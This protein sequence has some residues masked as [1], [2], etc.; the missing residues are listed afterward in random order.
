M[1]QAKSLLPSRYKF[2]T[3]RETT[4]NLVRF[5]YASEGVG[6]HLE[7][8]PYSE[9]I[10]HI[11]FGE[12]IKLTSPNYEIRSNY[13][14]YKVDY[15]DK[16][17]YISEKWI[18]VFPPPFKI[19]TIDF[20]A[21]RLKENDFDVEIDIYNME[22][23]QEFKLLFPS[24]NM[25]EIFNIASLLY[26]MDFKYPRKS[27][28]MEEVLTKINNDKDIYEEF[29]VTRNTNEE[30]IMLDYVAD[31]GISSDSITLRLRSDGMI[32]LV[33]GSYCQEHKPL[34]GH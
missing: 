13:K 29:E 16:T 26:P 3:K 24:E 17:L 25:R 20:Y 8:Y 28:M 7:P 10:T 18:G 11:P 4:E 1:S 6:L 15:E 30:V 22:D 27:N 19:E 32:L 14:W 21:E 5:V 12:T 23:R 31:F 34:E 9:E 33:L 2:V